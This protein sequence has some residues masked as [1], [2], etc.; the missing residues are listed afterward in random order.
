[1]QKR[2]VDEA[3]G[4]TTSEISFV[5]QSDSSRYHLPGKGS[6]EGDKLVELFA[7]RPREQRAEDDSSSSKD[8]LLPFHRWVV[9]A[10]AGEQPVLHDP[11]C[12]EQL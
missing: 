12:G 5:H 1:M 4:D 6:D 2:G 9:L 10:R 11:N 8:V 3:Q 7:S